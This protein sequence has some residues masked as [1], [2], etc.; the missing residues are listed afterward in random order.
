MKALDPLRRHIDTVGEE[1]AEWFDWLMRISEVRR[2]KDGGERKAAAAELYEILNDT[3][4]S[5]SSMAH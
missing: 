5:S 4:L 1:E 2:M 3:S